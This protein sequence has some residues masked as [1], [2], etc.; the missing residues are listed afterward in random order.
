MSY[1]R[2]HF[3]DNPASTEANFNV[4]FKD[5]H[6]DSNELPL[7]D[8]DNFIVP[9]R[10]EHGSH[11]TVTFNCPPLLVHQIDVAVRSNLFP[12]INRESFLRHAAVRHLRWLQSI[13]PESMEQHLAP[14]IESL[15]ER[16]FQSQMRKKVSSAF[17][18]L[19]ET[20]RSCQSDGEYMEVLRLCNFISTRLDSVGRGSVWQQRA[21]KKFLSEFGGYMSEL[22]IVKSNPH[23]NV[24][25]QSVNGHRLS[26]E[27][28]DGVGDGEI[29]VVQ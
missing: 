16:C 11:Q 13:R 27:W 18:T 26:N 25:V 21:W 2:R 6:P 14:A 7:D 12:Y 5:A 28:D 19:H 22:G 29:E 23:H 9:G 10:D 4:P 8:I 24:K 20:I 1:R 15:L 17:E 3:N